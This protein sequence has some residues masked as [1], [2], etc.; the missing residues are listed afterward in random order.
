MARCYVAPPR[1][2]SIIHPTHDLLGRYGILPVYD[3]FVRPFTTAPTF[4]EDKGKRKEDAASS[5]V[6]TVQDGTDDTRSGP[7]EGLFQHGYKHFI[8]DLGLGKHNHKKDTFLTDL[9]LFPEKQAVPIVKLDRTTLVHAFRLKEGGV[10][11]VSLLYSSCTNDLT[12]LFLV[13]SSTRARSP[14]TTRSGRKRS[15]LTSASQ[16]PLI[17]TL[18]PPHILIRTSYHRKRSARLILRRP[19]RLARSYILPLPLLPTHPHRDP[20]LLH[21]YVDLLH[22]PANL[23]MGM[24]HLNH[25]NRLSPP[26]GRLLS[27]SATLSQQTQKQLALPRVLQGRG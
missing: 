21:L 19:R 2:R 18:T 10:P 5:A 23:P 9:M 8:K 7:K 4:I 11:G 1:S 26:N 16:F 22:L 13:I 14:A 6:P 15:V 25:P 20:P 24:S 12:P 17:R 3:E 27:H